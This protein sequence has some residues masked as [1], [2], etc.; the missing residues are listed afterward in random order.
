MRAKLFLFTLLLAALKM[1]LPF[2]LVHPAFEL[3]R[4]EYLYLSEGHHL[5]WGYL[6][7][8]PLL[9][10][11]AWLSNAL[12]GS[13]F[14]V[15][16]WP[17]LFG[18]FTLLLTGKMIIS[19]G[20]KQLAVFLGCMPLLIGGYLRLFYL[21]HP[22]FLDVFFWTLMAY[23]LFNYIQ[24][25]KNKW[26]YMFGVAIGLGMMSKY[27]TAFY[28]VGLLFALAVSRHR[29]VFLNKHLYFAGL[30]ALSIVLPNLYWQY[31][32]NFPIIN[33]M[34]ELQ[35]E[36][37][38]F[39]KPADF[40]LSQ[41]LM[42]LPFLFIWVAGLLFVIISK[43]GRSFRIF[44]WAY[45]AVIALLIY[46]HG[47]DYYALG[48]YPVLFALGA[49]YLETV[50]E[51]KFRWV[52]Y[53]MV[54]IPVAFCLWAMPLVMPVAKPE[55]LAAY[56]KEMG[57]EKTGALR[58]EDQANHPLPQD[59]AD[60]VGWREMTEK[61]AKCYHSLPPQEQQQTMIYARGY[62]TAGALNYYGPSLRLPQVYSD[63]ASFLFWMPEKYHL[64]NLL[65]VGHT[66]PGKDDAVFQQFEKATLLDSVNMPLF[67]ENGMKFIL[68]EHGNDSVNN[69]IEKGIAEMKGKFSRK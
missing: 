22:N 12:G 28:A 41:I 65:L 4:D 34:E 58:W 46:L 6:E 54:A 64:K 45:A 59:F 23:S 68:F 14:W 8:P 9:S 35:E 67:R 38:Q 31:A 40:I 57:F 17:N 69:M 27:S 37:L 2:L 36:Q 61:A 10:V 62:Y 26:L 21:L 5:A 50:T 16:L 49:Y 60:M 7:V 53:A 63:N 18:V 3:H 51:R 32:H 29:K 15:K 33:H 48:A 56:Y 55:W 66:M 24:T 30:I 52:R 1:V 19:L 43:R 39:I 44:A 25:S 42:L 47:K 13:M 20:G 11:F